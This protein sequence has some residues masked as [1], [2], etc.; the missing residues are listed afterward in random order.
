MATESFPFIVQIKHSARKKTQNMTNYFENLTINFNSYV[1]IKNPDMTDK[2]KFYKVYSP[3]KFKLR[4][5]DDIDLD[6]KFNIQTPDRIELWLNLLPSLKTIGFHIE[7]DDW[8]NNLTKDKTV[9]LHTLNRNFTYT[10]KTKKKQC[11]GFIF[12][13]GER[14]ND[15]FTTKCNLI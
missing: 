6:L 13:L 2:T 4:P 15:I 14:Y 5:R 9:Q 11:I 8:K 10:I 7:N 1:G 3:K 12:L